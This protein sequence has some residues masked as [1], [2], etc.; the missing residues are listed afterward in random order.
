MAASIRPLEF[1]HG[2]QVAIHF[3]TY[4]D[5]QN[6][7]GASSARVLNDRYREGRVTG[8]GRTAAMATSENFDRPC[9]QRETLFGHEETVDYTP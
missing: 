3:C 8:S 5:T 9:R 6:K 2:G 4:S 7:L 1:S